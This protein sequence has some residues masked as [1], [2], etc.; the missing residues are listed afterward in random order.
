MYEYYLK[1]NDLISTIV[2]W[3]HLLN[4]DGNNEIIESKLKS[5]NNKI[6]EQVI[7]RYTLLIGNSKNIL[8]NK[9]ALQHSNA[10]ITINFQFRENRDFAMK[11]ISEF[12][13]KSFAAGLTGAEQMTLLNTIVETGAIEKIESIVL[14]EVNFYY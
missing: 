14:Q 10:S 11:L 3:F 5:L 13:E 4:D 6:Y 9:I 12:A 7:R 2:E 1:R 8:P